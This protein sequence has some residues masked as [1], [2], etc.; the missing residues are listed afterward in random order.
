[1][2]VHFPQRNHLTHCDGAEARRSKLAPADHVARTKGGAVRE[3]A[4]SRADRRVP[5]RTHPLGCYEGMNGTGF[6]RN[7]RNDGVK[8]H[9]RPTY[10][11][12]FAGV[13]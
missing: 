13:W 9:P 5:C 12:F 10:A 11:L 7:R 1:M 4:G 2:V 8:S 6:S 3:A